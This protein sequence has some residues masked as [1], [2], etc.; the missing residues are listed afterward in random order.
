[1]HSEVSIYDVEATL[2]EVLQGSTIITDASSRESRQLTENLLLYPP[3]LL[4]HATTSMAATQIQGNGFS[5][6]NLG[7]GASRQHQLPQ[8]HLKEAASAASGIT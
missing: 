7:T 3:L 2:I 4:Y 6:D 5:F 8:C 1:M